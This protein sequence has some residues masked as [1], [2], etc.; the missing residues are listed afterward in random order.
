MKSLKYKTMI[1]IALT[2]F[3]IS[4]I[5]G[6]ISYMQIKK[7]LLSKT[8]QAFIAI[9]SEAS[10]VIQANM[11][12]NTAVMETLAERRI[13][14]DDTP[15]QKKVESMEKEAKR[16]GFEVFS[17][18]DTDANSYR[19]N[20][21]KSPSKISDRDY[22]I[23]AIAG[24]PTYSSVFISRVSGLPSI[25]VA[26]PVRR[27]GKITGVFYGIR[28]GNDISHLVENIKIGETGYAY[29]V[30][31]EGTVQGHKDSQLVLKMYNPIKESSQDKSLNQLA[32]FLKKAISGDKG[33][34]QY[35]FK[36]HD[37]FCSY[38]PIAGTDG[39]FVV[40]AIEMNEL[41][42]DVNHL[43]NIIILITI[44]LT[45]LGVVLSY[46]IGNHIAKPI[47]AAATYAENLAR[48]DF[49]K[50]VEET[51]INRN[52]EIGILA[53]SFQIL[54]DILRTTVTEIIRSA[55]E[56]AVATVKI[57]DDNQ[58]LSQRTSEQA[59]SLE[60]IA[61]AV[62]EANASTRQSFDNSIEANNYAN[63]SLKLAQ[64]GGKNSRYSYNCD[65]RNQ[66]FKLKN[67]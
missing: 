56:V 27:D 38:A 25:S 50:D 15:W 54:I 22:Y 32:G 59:S 37:I 66:C 47:I 23:R 29:V 30:N 48:L 14:D 36:G 13:I 7:I 33:T 24:I 52:D 42:N 6:F 26:V 43:R 67:C 58:N 17:F 1:L 10:K 39:W 8:E 61:A 4:V 40:I 12:T 19:Y 53:R 46:Y 18:A 64:D 5:F 31:K 57:S 51:Y 65:W 35:F 11:R 49:S 20:M 9:T 45:I 28:D 63:N 41:L 44:A 21:E 62:E 2:V 16:T 3:I 34:A 60:E 55:Q